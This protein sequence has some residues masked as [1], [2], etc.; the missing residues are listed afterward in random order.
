ML[1]LAHYNQEFI[2]KEP[3]GNNAFDYE[4]RSQTHP[5][6]YIRIAPL[7]NYPN[8][9]TALQKFQVGITPAFE[10]YDEDKLRSMPGLINFLQFPESSS[11]RSVFVFDNHNHAFYFWHASAQVLKISEPLL[12]IHID[13]H[14]DSRIPVSFLS[15]AE[16]SDPKLLFEYT[17]YTLNVGNFIPP[18]IKTGLLSDAITIDSETSIKAFREP[19][20]PFI[21]D[22]DLDFFAPELDYIGNQQK[23]DLIRQLLPK[24]TITTIATS[25]YFIDQD[26]AQ[27]YLEAIFKTA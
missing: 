8:S 24:A 16:A 6:P 7:L 12:L 25:P 21:L 15:A 20:Q 2:L 5:E 22:I 10:I 4:R 3:F 13:Q 26:L 27:K 14:K 18:A 23:L 19:T 9:Q 1:K 11:G 17:N